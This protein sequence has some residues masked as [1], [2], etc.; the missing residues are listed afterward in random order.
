MPCKYPECLEKDEGIP[1]YLG[2]KQPEMCLCCEDV[3]GK[4]E[5]QLKVSDK[6]K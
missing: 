3:G 4:P 1:I 2:I 6:E 5:L